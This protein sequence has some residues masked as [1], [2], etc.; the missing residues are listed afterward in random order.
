MVTTGVRLTAR[1]RFAQFL[2]TKPAEVE[3][4]EVPAGQAG[5][6][7]GK[8]TFFETAPGRHRVTVSFPYLGMSKR[9]GEATIEVDVPPGQEV[10]LLYRSP[11]I[12]TNK[13]SLQ[14]S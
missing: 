9:A 11:W 13:G 2:I 12:M 10:A 6:G 8:P 1:R 4:D 14:A 3:V 7:S 5:W